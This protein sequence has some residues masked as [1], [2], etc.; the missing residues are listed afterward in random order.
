MVPTDIARM[1]G[2]VL[3]REILEELRGS[4]EA[5]EIVLGGYFAL[6]RYVDYRQTNDIDAWWKT[7]RIEASVDRIRAA[8]LAIARRRG[9]QLAERGIGETLSFEF[10][11]AGSRIFSFQI[12]PRNVE[13]RSAAVT[14]WAPILI[15]SLED[16]GGSK[17]NALV[18]RGAPR[19]F[20]DINAVVVR[21]VASVEQC[22]H[23][24]RE[25]N[26]SADPTQAKV[27]V[28]HH[29]EALEQRRP[30]EAIADSE[31]RARA[32]AMREWIRNVL[33]GEQE[34]CS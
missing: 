32:R 21:R 11:D 23:W 19:D 10:V 20:L 9:F 33:L 2:D 34:K 12:A 1:L 30:I 6:R 25:K 27:Q 17:M 13:L 22:W 14:E 3:A 26:P 16:T 7:G 28:L 18:N 5:A 29:L 24:W 31:E 8:M 15:E 4:P